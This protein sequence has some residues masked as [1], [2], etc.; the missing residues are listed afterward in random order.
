MNV[1][2]FLEVI[3]KS[4]FGQKASFN[5]DALCFGSALTQ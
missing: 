2:T 1:I 3:C 5:E 4:I